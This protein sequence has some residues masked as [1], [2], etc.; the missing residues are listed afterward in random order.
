MGE[1][2]RAVMATGVRGMPGCQGTY[3]MQ[4][5]SAAMVRIPTFSMTQPEPGELRRVLW[6]GA[7]V[8]SY[9]LPPDAQRP[10]NAHLYICRRA[11]YSVDRLSSAARRDIRR[12]ERGLQFGPLDA[13]TLLAN[14]WA[15]YR[16]TRGR[17]GLADGTQRDFTNRFEDFC[18]NPAHQILG[19]WN[20]C[21]L[22]AFMA[23]VVVDE[24]VEIQGSFS[25]DDNL[26]SCPNDG[27]AHF[28]LD[29]F[30]VRGG[31]DLVSY[32]LSSIQLDSGREGLHR[33]KCK[34]GFESVPV[35]RA[36]VMHPALRPF[37]NRL[38]LWGVKS[39]LRHRPT[40]RRMRKACGVLSE[41]L[42]VG[43]HGTMECPG[44]MA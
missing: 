35:H 43:S 41:I 10:A 12:A 5:E 15:A 44:H 4:Y 11:T 27:L 21:R 20:G 42:G 39:I 8:A 2:A 40:A 23:L 37:A 24:W 13:G 32:G 29:R 1:Y 18:R 26:S 28:V 33:Y 3:W 30:L 22:V 14:G 6:R 38:T 31:F 36:F 7:A 19:A 17:V 25:T 34:I 9:L 16:D